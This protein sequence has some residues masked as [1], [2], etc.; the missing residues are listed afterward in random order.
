MSTV[1][2]I[3]DVLR[4]ARARQ[5]AAGEGRRARE[6]A[7]LSLREV[8]D[9]LSIDVADLSRWERGLVRPRTASALR[10]LDVVEALRRTAST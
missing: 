2:P 6:E 5:L 9:A 10:W 4:V 8:A 7:G 3:N 1:S